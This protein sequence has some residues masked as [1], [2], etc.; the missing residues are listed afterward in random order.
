MTF[1]SKLLQLMQDRGWSVSDL[2]QHAGL[3]FTTVRSYTA[4]GKNKR[5]PTLVNALRLATALGVSLEEFKECSDLIR[6]DDSD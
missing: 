6:D 3:S 2:A 5:L 1:A 4:K